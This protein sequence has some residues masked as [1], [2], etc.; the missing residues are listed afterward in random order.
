MPTTQRA[1]YSKGNDA[2]DTEVGQGRRVVLITH[3]GAVVD[4]ILDVL[5]IDPDGMGGSRARWLDQE[6]RFDL[7]ADLHLADAAAGGRL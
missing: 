5:F 7:G 6:E 3:I 2:I 4:R 1:L